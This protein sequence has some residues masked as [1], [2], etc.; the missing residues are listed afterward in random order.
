MENLSIILKE[1]T[2]ILSKNNIPYVVIGGM[3]NTLYG[4]PR[5]T[6][7]ID[8]SLKIDDESNLENFIQTLANAGFEP[9]PKDI[10]QFVQDTRV[11]PVSYDKNNIQGQ[12]DLILTASVYEDQIF[13]RAHTI[14]I[15]NME[16]KVISPEDLIIHKWIAQRP[17]DLE[18]IKWIIEKNKTTLDK[19][20]IKNWVSQIADATEQPDLY[21]R[22]KELF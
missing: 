21:A 7:D 4:N 20:Y 15:E 11:I 22:L 1:I 5:M 12:C 10:K 3:A 17:V 16:I 6:K 2:S 18:D 13:G 14:S 8:I 19:S 9:I